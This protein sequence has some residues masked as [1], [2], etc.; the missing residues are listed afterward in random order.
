VC[1]AVKRAAT[2]KTSDLGELIKPAAALRVRLAA[3]AAQ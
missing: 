3:L 2:A 1:L